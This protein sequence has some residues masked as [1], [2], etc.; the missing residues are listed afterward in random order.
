MNFVAGN[1]IVILTLGGYDFIQLATGAPGPFTLFPGA[2]GVSPGVELW[3]A[4]G[5]FTVNV[6]SS[7]YIRDN[8]NQNYQRMIGGRPANI[9]RR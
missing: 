8:S 1:K 4:T 6:D 3:E 9:I 2:N 5:S 7:S